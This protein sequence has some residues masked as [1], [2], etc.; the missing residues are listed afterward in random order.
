[1]ATLNQTT[2]I[3]NDSAKRCSRC[4]KYK[5]LNDF[6]R[7]SKNDLKEFSSCNA[8]AEKRKKKRSESVNDSNSELIDSSSLNA[9]E[10][11]REEMN[12][13]DENEVSYDLV[14]LEDLISNCFANVEENEQVRFSGTFRFD[15]DL[16]SIS[17]DNQEIDE[18][19]KYHN[20]VRSFL[21][22][23]EA[24][25]RYYWEIRKIYLHK[26]NNQYTGEATAY[27]GCA[28]R[29]DRKYTRPDDHPS[30]R[31]SEARSAIERY[32]C[33]GSITINVNVN[34]CQAT[35][36]IQ[37]LIH[38]YP[39]YRENNLPQNAIAWISR[40]VNRGFR[41][42]EFYKRLRDEKLIN[43]NVHTYQQVYYW[44]LKFSA[45]QYVTNVSNQLLS[46]RNFLEQ[47][48][49][50]DQGYKVIFYLEND[51]VRALGFTTPFL[52][53]I[54]TNNI[55][56]IIIDSTFKTNQE[57]FE[58]FAVIN[59]CGGYGV[60]LGYL[61]VHT[62]T[63]SSEHLHNP[64]NNI[65]TR[66][67][68]L[69][70]FFSLLRADGVLP[71]FILLDKDAGQIAAAEEA[72]SWTANIQLCLWHVE[73]AV[74]RKLR[75]K[76]FKASQYTSQVAND[77]RRQFDFI[78]ESWIPDGQVNVLC[79]EK[80]IQDILKMIKK[81]SVL[82]PLIPINEG[83]FLTSDEIYQRSVREAYNY[84]KQKN[85]VCLWG[86][87]WINW[88]KK[89]CWHLFARA[90]YSKA[91]PLARTTMLVES[92][93]RVLK[94][95]YKHNSNRPRLDRLTQMLT[96]ELI[97]DLVHNWE[98][99]CSNRTFPSWWAAFKHDWK[100]ALETEVNID[101]TYYTDIDRWICS[102]HAFI[103]STYLLCKHLAQRYAV[104]HPNFFPQF[105]LTKRRH[106]YPLIC[107]GR[108]NVSCIETANSPWNNFIDDSFVESANEVGEDDEELSLHDR[109][110]LIDL[111]KAEV[112]EDK[113]TFESLLDIVSDNVENDTFYNTYKKLKQTLTTE[114]VACQE[115][116]RARRQQQT[117]DP[118]RRSRLAFWL[119]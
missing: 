39:T 21:P 109:Y 13:D 30:K 64:I 118:P 49:L 102:C 80:D 51:F 87:L 115:A 52:R 38:D 44:A 57:N 92:H 53:H 114:A 69:K 35:I 71:T 78:D 75:E 15:D 106:D 85:F 28:Q 26:K 18:E 42:I 34:K 4:E 62:T 68:I 105:L 54:Q 101:A 32:P 25:S 40:N 41:K 50:A 119:R 23:I 31:I 74:E 27:L 12:I 97:P 70:E 10:D 79:A 116:L 36:D 61:Y 16:F 91:L 56:E 22:T 37:H 90:S 5:I 47:Q 72:W 88:Y 17:Y 108:E 67:K 45:Q 77:A 95:N 76:K 98:K 46:S 94:Y 84:C 110:E 24:G 8:C 59:N 63:A 60:P 82:H 96:K 9:A 66:A 89:N 6:I 1:M 48:E 81:H 20:L 86:Y 93:W 19:N 33:G 14:D 104:E 11:N 65:N 7:P 73:H 112:E 43:P 29:E 100:I 103:G 107:F 3:T 113:K 99:Y 55:S 2:D 83:T 117:W 111:R 58:V